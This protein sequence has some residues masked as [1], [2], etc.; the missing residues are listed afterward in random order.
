MSVHTALIVG[1]RSPIRVRKAAVISRALNLRDA[2]ARAISTAV[3]LVIVV[4]PAP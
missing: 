2:T 4:M 3:R 1:L